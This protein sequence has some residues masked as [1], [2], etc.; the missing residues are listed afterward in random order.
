MIQMSQ[1][2]EPYNAA[3]CPQEFSDDVTFHLTPQYVPCINQGL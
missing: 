2:T 1:D 3:T